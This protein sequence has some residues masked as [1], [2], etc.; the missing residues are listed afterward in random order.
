MVEW[1]RGGEVVR[2]HKTFSLPY[3]A[4]AINLP[5]GLTWLSHEVMYGQIFIFCCSNFY[6]LL[7][8]LLFFVGQIV[9]FC[10]SN[11]YSFMLKF[12]ILWWSL[13]TQNITKIHKYFYKD[14]KRFNLPGKLVVFN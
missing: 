7:V 12:C 8:K 13:L 9:I 5:R 1:G 4:A 14:L 10:W 6:S 3:F 11:F 2:Q